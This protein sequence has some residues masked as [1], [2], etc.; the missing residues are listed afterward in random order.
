MFSNI[1][2]WVVTFCIDSQQAGTCFFRFLYE[3]FGYKSSVLGLHFHTTIYS[4]IFLV[5]FASCC[6]FAV[7]ASRTLFQVLNLNFYFKLISKNN[8]LFFVVLLFWNNLNKELFCFIL[9]KMSS[10]NCFKDNFDAFEKR[11][12]VFS[13]RRSLVIFC[14]TWS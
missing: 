2:L 9:E 6:L 12:C 5:K 3:I 10:Q 1:L 4:Q 11:T 13:S 8:L 14:W 7:V